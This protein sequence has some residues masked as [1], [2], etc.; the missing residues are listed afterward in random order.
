MQDFV[1]SCLYIMIIC[2]TFIRSLSF[3]FSLRRNLNNSRAQSYTIYY[4]RRI[5]REHK[6]MRMRSIKQKKD[7]QHCW[8]K[9]AYLKGPPLNILITNLR[10]FHYCT[11]IL[12]DEWLITRMKFMISLDFVITK[13]DLQLFLHK[14]R[15]KTYEHIFSVTKY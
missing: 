8:R 4:S 7:S 11:S 14:Y 3:S 6:M 10:C 2:I 15:Q 5:I 1:F 9:I 12:R 13:K